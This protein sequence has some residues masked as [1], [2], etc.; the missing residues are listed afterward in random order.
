MALASTT[1]GALGPCSSAA[2]SCV[3]HFGR[4]CRCSCAWGWKAPGCRTPAVPRQAMPTTTLTATTTRRKASLPRSGPGRGC[5][6]RPRSRPWPTAVGRR[7]SRSACCPH[8]EARSSGRLR[9]HHRSPQRSS[10]CRGDTVSRRPAVLHHRCALSCAFRTPR[11]SFPNQELSR[12]SE[13]CV[14]AQLRGRACARRQRF[15]PIIPAGGLAPAGQP[16]G[17]PNVS[18]RP[19]CLAPWPAPCFLPAWRR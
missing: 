1:C 18:I 15:V 17:A 16:T 5:A 12:R 19:R 11:S 9:R 4:R 13:K 2:S 10:A 3:R 7:R 6:V 8:W 14:T